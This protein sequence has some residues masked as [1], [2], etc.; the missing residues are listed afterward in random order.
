MLE[1]LSSSLSWLAIAASPFEASDRHQS[2]GHFRRSKATRWTG[3]R[4]RPVAE[5]YVGARYECRLKKRQTS[6]TVKRVRILMV[7]ALTDTSD[8]RRVFQKRT[9]ER[10][11][12][13][14]VFAR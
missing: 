10:H 13:G 1:L 14:Y 6:G 2:K 4:P 12:T 3:G 8:E 7:A 11:E 9:V 5:S